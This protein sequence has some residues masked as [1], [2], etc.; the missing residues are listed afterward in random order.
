MNKMNFE[1]QKIWW[2]P[3]DIEITNFKFY[4]SII[5]HN[6]GDLKNAGLFSLKGTFHGIGVDFTINNY[7]YLEKERTFLKNNKFHLHFFNPFLKT[8]SY[9]EFFLN[10]LEEAKQKAQEELEKIFIKTFFEP[11]SERNVLIEKRSKF[12]T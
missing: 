1:L 2:E 9:S 4:H 6:Q 3:K 11:I 5:A 12:K 8:K 7:Q 10:T